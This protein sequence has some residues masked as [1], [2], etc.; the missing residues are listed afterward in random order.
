VAAAAGMRVTLVDVGEEQLERGLATIGASLAKL[1]SKGQCDDPD[2]V[3]A[4][5][6]TSTDIAAA[7]DA[8]LALE[9]ASEDGELKLA[10]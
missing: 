10:G 1:A 5:I 3:L 9:A 4:R 6:A 2:G 8:E 7:A